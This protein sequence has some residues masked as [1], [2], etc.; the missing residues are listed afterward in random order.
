MLKKNSN[1]FLGYSFI[2]PLDSSIALQGSMSPWIPG[3]HKMLLKWKDF[4]VPME[5]TSFSTD[6]FITLS[7]V[8]APSSGAYEKTSEYLTLGFTREQDCIR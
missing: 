4:N 3:I 6:C 2:R 1:G 7:R 8:R 5:F